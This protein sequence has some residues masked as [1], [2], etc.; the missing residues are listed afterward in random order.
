MDGRIATR[1]DNDEEERLAVIGN[2]REAG[3][4][5]DRLWLLAATDGS[6]E[7]LRIAEASQSVH[8]ALIALSKP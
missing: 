3:A 8:R 4:T 1:T 6:D 5:L 2:L 7:A